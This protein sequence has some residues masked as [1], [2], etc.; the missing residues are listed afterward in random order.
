MENAER[1]DSL[2]GALAPYTSVSIPPGPAW[3]EAREEAWAAE[4][5]AKMG[6][7]RGED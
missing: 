2:M 3:D 7:E 5:A 6:V 1:S 4:M